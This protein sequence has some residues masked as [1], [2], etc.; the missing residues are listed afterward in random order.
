MNTH[1]ILP[2][3]NGMSEQ[4]RKKVVQVLNTELSDHY[5]LQAKTKFYHW[6]VRGSHFRDLHLLFD[7]QYEI[8]ANMVDELAEQ[9][10]KLGGHASGTLKSFLEQSRLKEDHEPA[11]PDTRDMVQ[12]LLNDHES[13]MNN[14]Y[15]EIKVLDEEYDDAVTSNKLQDISD[16]HHKMAWMLRM[17]LQKSNL[18]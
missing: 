16:Q 9:S 8:I 13:I 1:Q 4:N 14:L 2:V 7:E 17:I 5:L 18:E 12:N 11:I 10:L 15:K 3:N 6:N